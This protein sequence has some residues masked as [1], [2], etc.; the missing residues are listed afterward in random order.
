[1]NASRRG[2][3]DF[4]CATGEVDERDL[5]AAGRPRRPPGDHRG[6][7]RREPA[8]RAAVRSD[9]IESTVGARDDEPAAIGRP[10]RRGGDVEGP[11]SADA[12]ESRAVG[13]HELQRARSCADERD[14]ASVGRPGG[15]GVGRPGR[16]PAYARAVAAHDPDREASA[17]GRRPGDPRAI[18]RPGRIRVQA[19][20][21]REAPEGAGR[22]AE[23]IEVAVRGAG[24]RLVHERRAVG[25]PGGSLE[26]GTGVMTRSPQPSEAIQWMRPLPSSARSKAIRPDGW[27]SE[28]SA[29]RPD[30]SS[31]AAASRQRE[32]V[33][34]SECAAA[35]GG[36]S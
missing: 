24:A 35:A 17:A 23:R 7:A 21:L 26:P 31:S 18:R 5:S 6:P 28:A 14:R 33:T 10:G 29:G 27:L 2:L 11:L 19:R 4:E 16:Q 15:M 1:M 3:D 30:A 36:T 13:A 22:H 12:P 9:A 32:P 8:E 25:R 34:G 20:V